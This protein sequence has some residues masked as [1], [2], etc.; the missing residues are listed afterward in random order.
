MK[1]SLIMLI[2]LVVAIAAGQRA[3][4]QCPTGYLP[5]N[6]TAIYYYCD[7][8]YIE[9]EYCVEYPVAQGQIPGIHILNFEWVSE[10]GGCDLCG[11]PIGLNG[12]IP[13]PWGAIVGL[14]LA[15]EPELDDDLHDEIHPC[16]DPNAPVTTIEITHGGCYSFSYIINGLEVRKVAT[17]CDPSNI[18]KCHQYWFVCREWDPVHGWVVQSTAGPLVAP[19]NC[20]NIIDP[21]GNDCQ[22]IC[23]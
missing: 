8:C 1:K 17:A 10:N 11:L 18:E 13:M 21:N 23:E 7:D 9:V 2:L 14:I 22:S 20:D 6:F 3:E 16:D 5:G 19:F 12:N 15:G 4:A